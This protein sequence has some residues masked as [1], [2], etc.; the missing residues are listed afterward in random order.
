MSGFDGRSSWTAP[1]IGRPWTPRLL[2]M[3]VAATCW[4]DAIMEQA[5]HSGSPAVVRAAEAPREPAD[6]SA[7]AASTP[8]TADELPRIGAGMTDAQ[9]ARFARLALEG[10]PREFPNKPSNVMVSRETVL[11]P[12]EMHPVF[13]GSFDWHS[14]VHGHWMLI[15]SLKRYP[16]SS[17]DAAIRQL[18]QAQLT[19]EKLAAEAEY[20]RA[21]HNRNFERMY[22]WAWALRLVEEL[23]KWPDPLGQ[24]L[25][26][27]LRPLEQIIVART[28]AY[29][30]LLSFPI[31][32]GVHPDTAFALGQIWDYA[33]AVQ[34]DQLQQLVRQ[35]SRDY[36]L[37]DEAYPTRYEPSGEDF[38]SPGLNEA[39]L[40]RRVLE[41]AEYAEWLGR[42]FPTL[43]AGHLGNL[44]TPVEVS[45]L[46][47]GKIVHLAGLDLSRAWTL[48]SIAQALPAEDPRVQ[49]LTRAAEAHA[50]A[51]FRYVFSG[52][53]EGE[54]WLATFAVY[55]LTEV[56]VPTRP[57]VRPADE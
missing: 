35:R 27:N 2:S 28:M 7:P 19:A 52:H 11:S 40:L 55:A 57:L 39:D 6:P 44:L 16:G 30:P 34:N 43:S 33:V 24:Q 5:F 54:H 4:C 37:A 53:Y 25:A 12:Q 23:R 20:F 1:R 42:F 56:G 50:A 15:R 41:P 18:L 3:L 46:T 48:N 36:Y 45:D 32:T 13:Y 49:I 26:D 29:L 8:A 21:E 9:V 22:G 31:R 17:V 10:I 51:G 47:D 38:F 14:S